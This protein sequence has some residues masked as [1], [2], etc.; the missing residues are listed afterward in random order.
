MSRK[1][2]KAVIFRKFKRGDKS[3]YMWLDKINHRIYIFSHYLPKDLRHMPLEI[4]EAKRMK[5][6]KNKFLVTKVKPVYSQV[7]IT[8]NPGK[9]ITIRV[10]GPHEPIQHVYNKEEIDFGGKR[11]KIVSILKYL[12]QKETSLGYQS[13]E[14]KVALLKTIN[15]YLITTFLKKENKK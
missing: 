3:Q 11:E 14:R 15:Y 4:L 2:N 10:T 5:N 1:D 6:T 8:T 7:H 9:R 13:Y 12:A